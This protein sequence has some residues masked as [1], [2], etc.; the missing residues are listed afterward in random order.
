M[1]LRRLQPRLILAIAMGTAATLGGGCNLVGPVAYLIHGPEKVKR[2]CA[3]DKDKS[4][5]VFIDDRANNVPRRVLRVMMG[6]EA[7]KTLMSNRVVK[8]VISTQ[9]ALTVAGSDKSGKALSIAEVGEAVKAQVVVYATVDSFTL[10]PDGNTFA[11]TAVMRVRVVDVV[12]DARVWP[13]DP[14]GYPLVSQLPARAR[15]IPGT[16]SAR[17]QAE[18]ELAKYAGME[19]A[20]LFYKHEAPHGIKVPE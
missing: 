11:P 2:V 3:L 1:T 17:Y 6:E 7:E 5:V 20:Q 15:A 16:T 19:L 8:D 4:T 10:S 13:E 9:S 12:T 14:N 18:D